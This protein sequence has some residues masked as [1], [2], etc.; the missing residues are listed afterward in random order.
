MYTASDRRRNKPARV[1]ETKEMIGNLRAAHYHRYELP[2]L[3]NP[4]SF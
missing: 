4:V 2:L 3:N 1:L